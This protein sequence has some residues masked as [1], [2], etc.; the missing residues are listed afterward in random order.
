MSPAARI[1]LTDGT[2]V[3]V[4]ASWQRSDHVIG[5]DA[6]RSPVALSEGTFFT[7][8]PCCGATF[9]GVEG[10]VGG[11]S[12]Y[13]YVEGS[14]IPR[15]PITPRVGYDGPPLPLVVPYEPRPGDERTLA[16][17]IHLIPVLGTLT[18][19]EPDEGADGRSGRLTFTMEDGRTCCVSITSD[20]PVIAAA[21]TVH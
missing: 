3:T 15:S 10:G 14:G 6:D 18:G 2:T 9:K 7:L 4:P 11:R 8:T 20:A 21:T 5:V 17:T 19:V 16:N 13:G 1:D 12:C